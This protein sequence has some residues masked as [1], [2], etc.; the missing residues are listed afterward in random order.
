MSV[1]AYRRQQPSVH[2]VKI[3]ARHHVLIV[4]ADTKLTALWLSLAQ[5]FGCAVIRRAP[6]ETGIDEMADIAVIDLDAPG[7]DGLAAAAGLRAGTAEVD[8]PWIIGIKTGAKE[9]DVDAAMAA[10]M[11][12][13][14]DRGG[15]A[16]AFLGALESADRA[17]HERGAA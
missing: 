15:G 2:G 4:T 11:N 9:G 8:F 17:L 3:R 13:L 1:L 5:R 6:Q 10:G 14:V 12:D 7:H 16:D